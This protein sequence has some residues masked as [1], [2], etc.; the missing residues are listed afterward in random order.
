MLIK[1][2][3]KNFKS[4]RDENCLDMQAT[5]LKEHEYNVANINGERYLKVAAIYGANASGKTNVL[6]AFDF[7]KR[8]ILINDDTKNFEKEN[9]LSFMVNDKPIELEVDILAKNNNAYKYGFTIICDTI[10]SEWLYKRI[11]NKYV[12][13]FE[14]TD[15]LI[16]FP[17]CKNN[18]DNIDEKV[19]FLSAYN[20]LYNNDDFSN[21]Y[22]WFVNACYLN[23]GLKT[24]STT[25]FAKKLIGDEKYR[26]ET[27][28]FL[29]I[30]DNTIDSIKIT[31]RENGQ[32]PIISLIHTGPKGKKTSLPFLLE[33][34]GTI[35][36]FFLFDF[37]MQGLKEGKV[38]FI[39][40]LDAKLHPLLTRY[41]INL[42]HNKEKNIG[43]GQLIYSTHDT[44]N[45]NKETF[46][47]DEIWFAEKN[48][49]GVSE[50]Y[51][52]SDY[53]VTDK[54]GNEKKVRNDATY[55]KDYLTGRYGAIPILK[56][57]DCLCEAEK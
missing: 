50:L 30:F 7:M 2:S 46:R 13:I 25:D 47:R 22:N 52:L 39:D 4:F 17:S 18:F 29:K 45:L 6:D 10:K 34:N 43:N 51:S 37:L 40:E 9:T 44:I 28:K 42:F 15:S 55:S 54:N 20:K 53:V 31:P 3:F 8:V 5:V 27:A 26:E 32:G 41:I 24:E 35:K 49:E 33:S 14:R 21:V 19:L 38:L 12:K 48:S 16:D 56:E 36:M 11:E 57:F 23:L 1:F